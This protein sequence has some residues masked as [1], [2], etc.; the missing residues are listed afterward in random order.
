M[1]P[2]CPSKDIE[3]KVQLS[4]Q[5]SLFRPKKVQLSGTLKIVLIGSIP[6]YS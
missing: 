1:A 5:L 6:F 2:A 4:V 3:K